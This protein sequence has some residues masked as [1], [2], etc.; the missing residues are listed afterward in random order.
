MS[1]QTIELNRAFIDD[2]LTRGAGWW[3]EIN[4]DYAFRQRVDA[5][6]GRLVRRAFEEGDQAALL[7]IHDV[8][9][10]IYEQDFRSGAIDR[11]ECETQPL[12]R[13]IAAKFERATLGEEIKAVP[14][15]LLASRP[16]R[17][18]EYLQWLTAVIGDHPAASHSFYS[19]FL[20]KT[21][22]REDMRFYLAQETNLDP[23]F[24]DILALVQ[25]G[26]AGEEKLE[27]GANYWDE[28][29]NG[30]EDEVHTA[31]FAE[32]LRALDVNPTYIAERLLPEAK[33]SASLSSC[34]ALS[35]RHYFKAVGFFGVTEYLVPRRFTGFLEGWRRLGLPMAAVKYHDL[36]VRV[37]AVHAS[38]WFRNVIVPLVERDP[39]IGHEIALGALI[40]LNSSQRYLDSLLDHLTGRGG[41]D[42]S[43]R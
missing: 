30:E 8:L 1:D 9:S 21:A 16:D 35:R 37:D 2:L 19:T 7:R 34:L 23:R 32:S 22:T 12:F 10:A 28:M 18:G 14:E 29:G 4:F 40:R 39:R 3:D 38:G 20:A 41:K 31:L 13:D 24:D 36:H 42:P 27:I 5:A 6:C 26:T 43:S 17:P 33:V 15:D 25:I 11:V